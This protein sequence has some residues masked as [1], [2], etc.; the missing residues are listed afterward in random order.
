MNALL[1]RRKKRESPSA[2]AI[3]SVVVVAGKVWNLRLESSSRELKFLAQYYTARV[4]TI[5]HGLYN[6]GCDDDIIDTVEFLRS[7]LDKS[8][9]DLQSLLL[10]LR[11]RKSWLAA[12]TNEAALKALH[13]ASSF[14]LM[15]STTGWKSTETLTEFLEGARGQLQGRSS[16]SRE[17]R[18]TARG[19]NQIAGIEILWTSDIQDHLRYDPVQRTISIFRH[20]AFL[21][22]RGDAGHSRE[23][24]LET[25]QT[26]AL[27][28][29]YSESPHRGWNRRIRRAQPDV[30]VG[31]SSNP[32]RDSRYY[33]HWCER[34]VILQDAF[35]ASKPQRLT[36]W[37]HD[38][39]DGNQ[40]YTFWL[41]VTAITLTLVFGL[42]QSIT[43]ILQVYLAART[44]SS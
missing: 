9:A 22:E 29:P 1:E 31:F 7:N 12:S 10:N 32:T 20:G 28:F 37:Y 8:L 15:M 43:G 14:W 25:A 16:L 4:A 2:N 24:L 13:F 17:L 18:I 42:V 44:N 19:L 36:Q 41:A 26:L 30:E 33:Q 21:D 5:D 35:D 40:F 11:P 38:K 34:L 23:F 6:S 3:A 39:R 27:L